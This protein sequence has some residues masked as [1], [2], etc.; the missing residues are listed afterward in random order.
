M[1]RII[2]AFVLCG[3][4]SASNLFSF[5]ESDLSLGFAYCGL[6]DITGKY[7]K[8]NRRL[9]QCIWKDA[10]SASKATKASILYCLLSEA[11]RQRQFEI[12]HNGCFLR[13]F[14][15][16]ITF[17]AADWTLAGAESNWTFNP[18]AGVKPYIG[19][20]VNMYNE[21]SHFGKPPFKKEL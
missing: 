19:F 2:N 14:G 3:L 6:F 17:T 7:G 5:E 1:K 11:G 16:N 8:D 18:I 10:I 9:R 13:C 20:G 15:V 4:V 12:R 21:Y